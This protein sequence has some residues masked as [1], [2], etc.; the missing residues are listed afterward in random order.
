M[1]HATTNKKKVKVVMVIS[2]KSR[3]QSKEN[4]WGKERE[5]T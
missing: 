5:I 1:Y 3:L 4:A 2:E